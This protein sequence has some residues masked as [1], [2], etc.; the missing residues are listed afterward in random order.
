MSLF[1]I[2]FV[3]APIFVCWRTGVGPSGDIKA[4]Y[5]LMDHCQPAAMTGISC[6]MLVC[7]VSA[8]WATGKL[9]KRE[10]VDALEY[11]ENLDNVKHFLTVLW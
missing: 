1:F 11:L 2:F 10:M 4:G 5:L 9:S 8:S 3:L 7:L 6:L